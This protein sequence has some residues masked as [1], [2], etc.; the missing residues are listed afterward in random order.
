[1]NNKKILEELFAKHGFN[2]YKWIN[3]KDIIVS[4]WVRFRCMYGCTNYGK[5]GTCPPNNVPTIQETKDF[6]SEYSNAVIFHLAKAV[7]KPEDRKA[8]SREMSIKMCAME[9]EVFL[10]G[11]YK[12]FLMGFDSCALC[13]DC[14]A[15]RVDC[16]NPKNS[17]P[18][19]DALGVD[20]FGTVRNAGYYIE[21]LKD[22]HETMNRYAI[23]LVE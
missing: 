4:Q 8:W 15:S 12:A 3:A 17:R 7:D 19:A 23:L 11:H 20:V 13:A 2:E 14:S 5:G 16:K 22:Y 21:V 18:G 10:A 1:L 9:R 6:V